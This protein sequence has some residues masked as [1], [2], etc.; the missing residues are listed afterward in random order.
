MKTFSFLQFHRTCGIRDLNAVFTECLEHCFA[1]FSVE[2]IVF[3]TGPCIDAEPQFN[4]GIQE[5]RDHNADRR[6]TG[7]LL[8][9]RSRIDKPF[10]LADCLD[11]H[12]PCLVDIRIIGDR[13]DD[14]REKRFDSVRLFS[15]I[16]EFMIEFGMI[17]CVPS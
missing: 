4:A 8:F 14:L 6:N 2:R 9:L 15:T 7:F 11:Q 1:H 12:F 5:I 17:T 13:K 3:R 10:G 16:C